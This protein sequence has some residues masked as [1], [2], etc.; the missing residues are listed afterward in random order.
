MNQWSVQESSTRARF[1]H[2][3]W[4][5]MV[6]TEWG[7]CLIPCTPSLSI[8]ANIED[9]AVLKSSHTKSVNTI[10]T[11]T[12][13]ATNKAAEL[14]PPTGFQE[15]LRPW[16]HYLP[17]SRVWLQTEEGGIHSLLE[18]RSQD[19]L[20]QRVQVKHVSDLSL[21]CLPWDTLKLSITSTSPCSQRLNTRFFH[22]VSLTWLRWASGISVP[23]PKQVW[24]PTFW[25]PRNVRRMILS[26]QESQASSQ[27]LRPPRRLWMCTKSPGILAAWN[28]CKDGLRAS[29]LNAWLH[30]MLGLRPT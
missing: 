9:W 16:H 14:L 23:S 29:P 30:S 24:K 4:L 21:T 6:W 22:T 27:Y 11:I 19:Y 1:E 10:I 8:Q 12:C 15:W 7:L 2:R 17:L 26:S 25:G 28:T 20:E 13:K 3:Y 18:Q 5:E